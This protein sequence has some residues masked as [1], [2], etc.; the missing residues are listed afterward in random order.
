MGQEI[1]LK[2]TLA[3]GDV[4]FYEQEYI[5]GTEAL[6]KEVNVIEN[7]VDKVSVQYRGEN[8]YIYQ[9]AILEAFS[10]TRAKIQQIMDERDTMT[11][12]YKYKDKDNPG[13]NKSVIYVPNEEVN[14]YFSGIKLAKKIHNLTF[15]QVAL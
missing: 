5:D 6:N 3:G 4:D 8:W 1:T 7:D 9:I 10:T 11:L 2:F 14:Y 13:A 15:L 12:Y